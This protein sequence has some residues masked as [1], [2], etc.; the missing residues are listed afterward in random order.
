MRFTKVTFLYIIWSQLLTRESNCSSVIDRERRNLALNLI[1]SRGVDVACKASSNVTNAI[2]FRTLMF[3]GLTFSLSKNT[4]APTVSLPFVRIRPDKM[5]RR[6]VFRGPLGPII[7][8][9][10]FWGTS[11][12]TSETKLRSSSLPIWSLEHNEKRW[13]AYCRTVTSRTNAITFYNL[14]TLPTS[15]WHF[16]N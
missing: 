11:P 4:S 6:E 1:S 16:S 8:R 10:F 15:C 5:L 13:T 12:Q 7:A 2:F 3:V 9:N 14:S